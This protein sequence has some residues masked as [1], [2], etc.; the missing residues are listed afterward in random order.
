MKL[1]AYPTNARESSILFIQRVPEWCRI[2][3]CI[4]KLSIHIS[5]G[6]V[7]MQILANFVTTSTC[8]TGSRVCAD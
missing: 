6:I 1:L 2:K 7:L 8:E 4:K 3:K 5:S